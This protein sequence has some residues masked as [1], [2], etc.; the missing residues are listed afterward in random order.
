MG[1]GPVITVLV[2]NGTLRVGDSFICGLY[3]GRVRAMLDVNV[4]KELRNCSVPILY[5]A[6]SR[7]RIVAGKALDDVWVCRPDII[8]RGLDGPHLILQTKPAES[9]AIIREF[10]EKL[11]V[12]R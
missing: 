3:D 8:I 1:K 4:R 10:C 5:I 7:D 11:M 6:P 2:Q 12:E 9:A